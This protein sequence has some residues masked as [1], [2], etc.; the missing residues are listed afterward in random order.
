SRDKLM[1]MGNMHKVKLIFIAL[2]VISVK[3][4]VYAKTGNN[5]IRIIGPQAPVDVIHQYYFH[6]LKE[7]IA[8][9]APEFPAKKLEVVEYKR[10][11]FGLSM[12]FLER[13]ITDILWAGTSTEREQKFIAIRIPLF[14]G[15]LG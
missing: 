10:I 2:L 14:K 6:L 9:S 8:N 13:D 7:A 3:M 12:Y 1:N 15:L 4:N 11:D 5:T